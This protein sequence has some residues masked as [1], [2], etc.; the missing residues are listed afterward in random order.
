M[1]HRSIQVKIAGL[2]IVS[3]LLTAIVLIAAILWHRGIMETNVKDQ[4]SQLSRGDAAVHD[5]GVCISLLGAFDAMAWHISGCGAAVVVMLGILAVVLTRTLTRPIIVAASLMDKVAQGNISVEV[6][7]AILKRRDEIGDL[8]KAIARM[9]ENLRAIV[10]GITTNSQGL[11]S[12]STELSATATQLAGGAEETTRQSAQVAAA[13]E[14]MTTNL[15]GMSASAEQMSTN[16]RVVATA[17]DGLTTA[18]GEVAESAEKTAQVVEAAAQRASTSNSQ[19]TNLGHAAEEIGTVIEVIQD[20]AEQTNLLALNAT[21]EA[22]RAGDAGKGFAVVATEVKELA[23]QTGSATE[24]IRKRIELIQL[25]TDQAVK[26]VA[27]FG[28]IIQHV[29]E[30]SRTIA[31]AVEEQNITTKEIAKNVAESSKAAESVARGVAETACVSREIARNIVGVDQAA[32][33][34]AQGAAQTQTASQDLSRVSEQ[35]HGLLSQ[36]RLGDRV[37][38]D[39][40]GFKA[41]HQFWVTRVADLMAGRKSLDPSEI[42]DHHKCKFGKW[43]FGEGTSIFGH[44]PTFREMDSPHAAVHRNARE[45]AQLVVEGRRAEA[46]EQFLLMRQASTELCAKLD[47]LVEQTQIPAETAHS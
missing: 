10:V 39:V 34:A 4:F 11:A 13:A 3:A 24:D 31:S 25:S 30:M 32:R 44:L 23:K 42:T 1:K 45:I 43:Y 14:Q 35:I 20:I 6:P 15:N 41:A 7:P 12:A 28:E 22:A 5:N 46:N 38:M 36:L 40:H 26:S 29:N 37:A 18:I 17:V 27:E 21:I 2:A 47:Q 16:A 33:Q 9:T 8:A 19:I